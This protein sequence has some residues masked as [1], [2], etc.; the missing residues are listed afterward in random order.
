MKNKSTD[1]RI[2]HLVIATG[3]ASVVT[4]LQ[5]IRE[6]MTQFQG[7]EFVIA[8]ILFNWL[9]LGGIGT[10]SAYLA[11]YRWLAPT[12]G[13]LAAAA[14]M[15]AGLGPVMLL[16]ARQLRN[17]LFLPGSAVGFYATF[18]Y[19]FAVIA[20]YCVLV[21]FLLP[22]SLFCAQRVSPAFSGTRVYI[23][24]NFGDIGGGALFSFVL[25][26]FA[27]PLQALF[28]ANLPLLYAAYRLLPKT[29]GYRL[30][31]VSAVLVCLLVLA[32]AIRF[33]IPS[34]QP[35]TGHLRHYEESRYGRIEVHRAH[36]QHSLFIDGRP[37][38]SS[39]D[40]I[41]AE[42]TV[43]Y[44]LS[45][46][47]A[48]ENIL[49]ISGQGGIMSEIKKYEPA[50]VDYVEIDPAVT[51]VVFQY[52]LL[53][54]YAPVNVIH[55]DGRGYLS[56]TEK[57][58][59][60]V[61]LNLP[62]PE[63][64]QINRFFTNRFYQQVKTRLNAG[65][66]LSFSI[67]GVADYISEAQEKTISI[68]HNTV[69]RHFKHV[70]L[71]PGRQLYF[72][73]SDAP[74]DLNI[75][76]RLE[77]KRIHTD[78]ISGYFHGT[79]TADRISDL[80]QRLN[81]DAPINT[82]H[83]PRLVQVM[84]SQWFAEFGASPVLFA[85]VLAAFLLGYMVWINREAFVL[86]TTGF[87]TMG[88]EILVIFAFQVFFG[89]IYFE[90]GLIVT[91][92]LAGLLPGAFIGERLKHRGRRVF[93]VADSVL[94]VCMFLFIMGIFHVGDRLPEAFFLVF[95]FIVSLACG[96]QFPIALHHGGGSQPAAV[97]AF[98][99]DLIGAAFGT[100]I[101]SVVLMP[102]TGLAWTAFALIF[103]KTLSFLTVSVTKYG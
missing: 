11:R 82:D 71:L 30:P 68:I 45:Q 51:E 89:Y 54:R 88:A 70:L 27:T 49:L 83:F 75:P 8:L 98:S 19:T 99:A 53:A 7:N 12:P 21:G 93:L 43:H 22:Y 90:I 76:A 66:V 52:G 73:C 17:V 38:L 74:L 35:A 100:L 91:V 39:H 20:P 40:V 15:L 65:G 13:R 58:Y 29:A 41:A 4:Q 24:D 102:Y 5:I 86:F 57:H 44:P 95:G 56:N 96:A 101:T 103:L 94:I 80:N 18:A 9:V 28:L 55:E 48:V 97:K 81:P 87:M 72:V 61:L 85:V 62:A 60:A 69:S 10:W 47:D 1:R 36:E 37:V 78:Y 3:I 50:A 46:L 59:D 92:F 26:F 67:E 2:V 34:L 79:M 31:S 16:A 6:F 25:V 33:E 23:A 63:T 32:G 84:F 42:E 77:Q 14:L 64:F